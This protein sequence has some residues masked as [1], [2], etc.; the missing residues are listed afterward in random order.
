MIG[1]EPISP[2]ID[3]HL[4]LH[5]PALR[6]ALGDSARFPGVA[7]QLVNGTHPGDWEGVRTLPDNGGTRILRAYGVHPWRV[8]SLPADWEERLRKYLGDGAASVG[9]IGLDH[10][11][12]PRDEARQVE[13][14]DRQM[15]LARELGLPPTIHCLRAWGL[16][17]E[18]LR[19]PAQP[20]GPFLVHA[21]AGSREVLYPL[22]DLGAFFS[23]SAYAADPA[24]KRMREA[25]RACPPD[26]LLAETDA[27]DMVPPAAVCRFPLTDTA[28]ERLHHPSEIATAH[29]LIAELRG[30]PEAALAARLAENFRRI[31]G[32]AC[33]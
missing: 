8:D 6:A 10:W 2:L 4:H 26:R 20:S 29:A 32:A 3:A 19:G 11:I 7:V 17:L 16:L 5:D 13:V 15:H 28:G 12:E 23:F 1:A 33:I 27:P 25:I 30:E 31:F 21:F 14:F 9:E 18:R 24:R 22:L